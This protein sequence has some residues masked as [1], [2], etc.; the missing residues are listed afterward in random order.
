[1]VIGIA[2]SAL[3]LW[4]ALRATDLAAIGRAFADARLGW[5]VP[6][7]ASFA[8]TMFVKAMRWQ[9]LLRPNIALRARQLLPAILIG[10]AGVALLPLQLGEV[11][12]VMVAARNTGARVAVLLGSIILERVLD[13][14]VVML[15]LALALTGG[16]ALHSSLIPAG[17]AL[18]AVVVIAFILLAILATR[19]E[20]CMQIVDRLTRKAPAHFAARLHTFIDH[21]RQGVGALGQVSIFSASVLL[22]V[23]MWLGIGGCVY[24]SLAA[25]GLSPSASAVTMTIACT[26]LAMSLPAT[27]GYVGTIQAA[28]VLA[29]TPFGYDASQVFAASVIYHALIYAASVMAGLLYL[30]RAGLSVAALR[31]SVAAP[32]KIE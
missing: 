3:F 27:P 5:S 28:Y 25:V 16:A 26:V 32:S 13:L 1:M 4:L 29:L 20:W 18:A 30:R 22:S 19:G 11:A 10:Y 17:Y 7:L 21:A 15:A 12:R 31:G 23:V 14:L 6:L 8:A 2:L 24:A 9:V